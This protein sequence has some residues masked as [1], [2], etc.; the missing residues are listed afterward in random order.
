MNSL[1]G[2]KDNLAYR[3]SQENYRLVLNKAPWSRQK[4]R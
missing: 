4:S 2:H 3:L 1:S